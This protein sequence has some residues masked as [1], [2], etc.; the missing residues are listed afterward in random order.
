MLP[1]ILGDYAQKL[2]K[3]GSYTPTP[4]EVERYAEEV[5]TYQTDIVSRQIKLSLDEIRIIVSGCPVCINGIPTEEMEVTAHR[6]LLRIPSNRIRGGMGLVVTEGLGLKAQKVM[7]WAKRLGLD[8]SFLEKF[9]KVEKKADQ[10]VEM[11][12][13]WKYLEGV[14]AGRPLL[15][16]PL[17]WGGFRIR[18]GR[19]RNT[20]IA[21]KAFNPALMHILDDFIAVG[22]HMRIERPGKAAQIFPVESIDGPTVLLKDGTVK[23]VNT[24]PDAQAIRP[25]VE[26]ILF[27][28]DMLITIG[29]FRKAAHPLVPSPFVPEWWVGLVERAQ[30]E[31]KKTRVDTQPYLQNP[32]QT[33]SIQDAIAISEQLTI[34]LHPH[35]TWFYRIWTPEETREIVAAIRAANDDVMGMGLLLLPP[36]LK[37][38]LERAGIP[39]RINNEKLVFDEDVSEALRLFLR[40]PLPLPAE[41]QNTLDLLSTAAGIPI[42]DRAGVFSGGR[43]GRPEAATPRTMK[44][45][46]HVLFPIGIAG[47]NTRSINRAAGLVMSKTRTTNPST[48]KVLTEIALYECPTCHRLMASKHCVPCDQITIAQLGCT[49][50][51]CGALSLTP[52]CSRCGSPTKVGVAHSVDVRE[53]LEW[54]AKN[55][56][57]RIPE[58]VKGVKGLISDT[59]KA[60]PLEKGILRAKHD[61]HVF[62][63]GT[64]RFEL[65][66]APLTH[67]YP[68]E[69]GMSIDRAHAL[70]YSHDMHGN[71]L[72]KGDQLVELFPQDIVV[73]EGCGDWL[74]RAMKYSDDLLTK[75]YKLPPHFNAQTKEDVIGQLVIGLAPHT[76]A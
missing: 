54:A 24:L 73:N 75:F 60:E 51:E 13:N 32:F 38:L 45:N 8:W 2:L 10:I 21:G 39:H 12:P 52:I 28:G 42:L 22:T 35:H 48:G 11:K 34:P 27:L 68:D 37:R 58:P 56:S 55:L 4:E 7:S 33:P 19:S 16:Y 43:M 15:A 17:E 1:L 71:P 50:K 44:G 20:G 6:N 5:N 76:S 31:G 41:D 59:K 18:Y 70:G 30:H 57:E 14:A 25:H 36:T 53:H 66:N 9:I 62:R 47:G 29:D 40:H 69:L 67:F 3:L 26:K 64:S 23:Q 63:D 65:L 61:L 74:L 46:P 72:E 49:N